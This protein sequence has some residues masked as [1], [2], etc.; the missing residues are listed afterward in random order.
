VLAAALLDGGSQR[1]GVG[2]TANIDAG[3]KVACDLGARIINMSFGT[4]ESSV[5]P[6]G[7]KPHQS[8]I[9]YAAR[10]GCVLIAAAGNNGREEA[11]YP[12]ALPEVIAV[13]SVDRYNQRS[14][15]S[16]FGKHLTLCAPG[17]QIVSLGRRG[18]KVSTGTS[19]AAPFVTGVAALLVARAHRVGCDLAGMDVKRLL[20][21][22]TVRLTDNGF[23][24]ETGYGLL[25]ALAAL[26]R[27]DRA[28]AGGELAQPW[29]PWSAR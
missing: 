22:S 21:D 7:P 1:L 25:D 15:F 28:L 5:S 27:L 6:A 2:G 29:Q 24:K 8:V 11:F 23:S 3:L 19:H 12:A 17:E 9:Q 16:T 26:Q 20:S 18:Y 13:G 4:P 14:R 10:Q